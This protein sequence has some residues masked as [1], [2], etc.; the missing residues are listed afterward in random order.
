M[1]IR[2]IEKKY[3]ILII[4]IIIAIIIVTTAV[5][6][7]YLNSHSIGITNDVTL[8][9]EISVGIIIA[10]SV[11]GISRRSEIEIEEKI[12]NVL[13]IVKERENIQKEKEQ[14]VN[15]SILTAFKEIKTEII[16]ISREAESYKALEDSIQKKFYKEQIILG[17]ERIRN[18]SIKHLDDADKIS[19]VFIKP[20]TVN[21]IRTISALCK[22]KPEFTDEKIANVSYCNTIKQMIEPIIAELSSVSKLAKETIT[23]HP[24]L[25][26]NI[27][28]GS[29]TVSSDRT[30]YP[31]DSI[32]HVRA[33]IPS[34]I[35]GEKILFEVFNSKRKLLLSQRI[36]PTKTE[37]PDLA[38]ANLFQVCFK[39]EGNEWKVGEAYIVRA[40]HGSSYS[41][42]S[43]L[44]DQRNSVIQSDKSVYM[45]NSD[46]ILT[47]ID[48]DA[49]KDNQ[50]AEYVGDTEDSKLIIESK[51]GKIEGYKLRET[52]D[53]TGIFQGIIGILGVRK[54]GTVIPRSI[55]GKIIDKIQGTGI[56]NG[57]I[58]GAP[59]EEIIISYKNKSNVEHLSIFVSNFGAVVEMDQ[60][61]YCPNDKVYLTVVAPDFNFDSETVDEI[62][63]KPESTIIIRTSKDELTNYKLVETGID[64]GIFTGEVQLTESNDES[65]RK[66]RRNIGPIDGLIRCSKDDF[67]EVIFNP[68]E[69][70]SVTG[71]ALI[72]A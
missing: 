66:P 3:L 46:M 56:D 61:I 55:D 26:A 9:V 22:N 59:G 4:S 71:R 44:I 35:E 15:Y 13:D 16:Q 30:V 48:P 40:T 18:L 67:I 12:S 5:V 38:E 11:Y 49:D 72:K 17:C 64:S 8:V 24:A 57:F 21:L 31:L 23:E 25:E 6:A 51:Y 42:D 50:V 63:Q 60:K 10:L 43:F 45:I 36:N 69:N 1:K 37:Y 34:I 41:E 2:L 33:N 7:V 39:M 58:G 53:S 70:E 19:S 20:D 62:G 14:Q 27:E 32:I 29:M 54:D 65:L 28:Y 52:G 68:F 47:V